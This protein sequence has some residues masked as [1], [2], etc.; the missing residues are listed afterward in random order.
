MKKSYQ[1]EAG[2]TLLEIMLVLAIA[3][4]IIV[5]SVRYY[6][7]SSSSQQAT[8]AFSQIQ[9]ITAAADTLGQA[10]GDYT[11]ASLASG[12]PNMI[13]SN[14]VLLSPWNTSVTVAAASA[15]TYTV[16]I[17]AMPGPVC[18]IIKAQLSANP[19]HYSSSI[20]CGS[21]PADFTYTYT[22]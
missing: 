19:A 6:Q 15:N 9:S 13:G 12:V 18:S 22:R 7:S 2:V 8:A 20:T 3:A 17:T 16:T 1:R 14:G 11:Q 5:M 21:A 4:M 10:T